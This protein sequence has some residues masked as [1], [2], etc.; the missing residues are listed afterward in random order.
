MP[1]N[2]IFYPPYLPNRR[3]YLPIPNYIPD[4]KIEN[5]LDSSEKR[6]ENKKEKRHPLENLFSFLNL[7]SDDLLI[8]AILFCLYIEKCNNILLYGILILLLLDIDL[9]SIFDFF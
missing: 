6:K 9:D 2:N 7:E 5:K 8:L 1:Y 4:T 3:N